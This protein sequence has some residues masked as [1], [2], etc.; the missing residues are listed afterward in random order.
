MKKRCVAN[1]FMQGGRY[2][3]AVGAFLLAT[4]PAAAQLVLFDTVTA[5]NP[6][7]SIFNTISAFEGFESGI[8]G[9]VVDIDPA[10]FGNYTVLTEPD[11][12]FSDVFGLF[13]Q[14]TGGL[15]L[16]FM[17]DGESGLT[18]VPPEFVN[19]AGGQPTMMAE[20]NGGPFSATKY[21]S[22]TLQR[23]GFTATFQS[24]AEAVVPEPSTLTL[25]GLGCL[26]LA[27]YAWR[28]RKAAV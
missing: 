18:S 19:P 12:T 17:S 16:G 5:F 23:R 1:R 25:L 21:L 22:P 15:F 6:N 27:G 20:G 2:L 4:L 14:S 26:G 11:G 24:D 9:I 13:Q 28:Q 8:F 10:Q 7:G 3:F